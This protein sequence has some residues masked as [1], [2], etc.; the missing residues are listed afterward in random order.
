MKVGQ[1]FKTKNGLTAKIVKIAGNQV[2][3][4]VEMKYDQNGKIPG[5]ATGHY[6]DLQNV[7]EEAKKVENVEETKERKEVTKSGHLAKSKTPENLF[8]VA[9]PNQGSSS[10]ESGPGTL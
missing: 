3:A 1:T 8:N 10:G 7:P 4:H 5:W 6:L 2:I 9:G